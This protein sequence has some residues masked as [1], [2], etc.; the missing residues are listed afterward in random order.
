MKIVYQLCTEVKHS[1]FTHSFTEIVVL[2][3]HKYETS[4]WI[5]L[6]SLEGFDILYIRKVWKK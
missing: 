6:Q 4:A 2:S 1:S 5:E 3:E